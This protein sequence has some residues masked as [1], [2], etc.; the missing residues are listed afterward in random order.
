MNPTTGKCTPRWVDVLFGQ[1]KAIVTTILPLPVLQTI[2]TSQ[3]AMR[4]LRLR[5]VLL[6]TPDIWH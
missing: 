1:L 3:D 6:S 2:F 4:L 5:C